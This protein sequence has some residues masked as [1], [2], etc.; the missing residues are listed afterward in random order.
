VTDAEAAG[1]W[2]NG[3]GG[4]PCVKPLQPRVPRCAGVLLDGAGAPLLS[5]MAI[6]GTS[7]AV[8]GGRREYR[9]VLSR[10]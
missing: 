7:K 4:E 8:V 10:D 9:R 5:G 2:H 1:L 3:A 6:W